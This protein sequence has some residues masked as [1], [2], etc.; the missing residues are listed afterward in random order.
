MPEEIRRAPYDPL[1]DQEWQDFLR[2]P[3]ANKFGKLF[4]MI[5]DKVYE[6]KNEIME[7]I[8][9]V[10]SQVDNL[11]EKVNTIDITALERIKALSHII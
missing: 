7:L 9:S 10:G 4:Y 11:Q 2:T 6:L 3:D 8:L 5:R 1:K